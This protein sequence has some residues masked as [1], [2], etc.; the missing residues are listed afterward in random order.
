MVSD[1][2]NRGL[3][4]MPRINA[5]FAYAS[6]YQEVRSAIAGADRLV[7]QQRRDVAIHLWEEN[8]V[9]GRALTDPI[10][11]KIAGS[12]VLIADVTTINFNVTF[13]VGYAIGLGKR[14]YLVRNANFKRDRA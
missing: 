12:D 3:A 13:E 4:N 7:S 1:P 5:F 9:S 14:V 8:D 6:T 2:T 10:F 11:Q